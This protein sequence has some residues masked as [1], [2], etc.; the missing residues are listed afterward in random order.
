[1]DSIRSLFRINPF[2]PES[3]T[4][5]EF[6]LLES[7]QVTLKIFNF[8]GEEHVTLIS[9]PQARATEQAFL[10]FDS[11]KYEWDASNMASMVYLNRLTSGGYV[12]IR[13]MVLMR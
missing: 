9:A 10:L 8:L 7:S 2:F 11:H 1:M 3:Y 5:I 4:T 6:K 13:K 12:E